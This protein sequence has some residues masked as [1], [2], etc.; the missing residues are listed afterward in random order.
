MYFGLV[1]NEDEWEVLSIHRSRDNAETGAR[2]V[3]GADVPVIVKSLAEMKAEFPP[4]IW[5][6]PLAEWRL[7]H[8]VMHDEDGADYVMLGEDASEW[9]G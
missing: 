4:H 7:A 8:S 9:S 2:F 5:G 6:L 1:K 3:A